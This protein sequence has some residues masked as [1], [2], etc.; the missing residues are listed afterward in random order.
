MNQDLFHKLLIFRS[1]GIGAVKYHELI[2]NC[3]GPEQAVEALQVSGDLMDSVRREIDLAESLGIKFV[4]DDSPEF[5]EA[6]KSARNHA[7]VLSVRGNIKT[8]SK[9]TAGMVGTR[10]AT[11][12]GIEFMHNLAAEFAKRGYAVVS[13]MAMG[14]DSAAHLGALSAGG[15]SM[16]IAVMAGGAD[17]IW[18]KENERLYHEIVERGCVVSDMPVGFVPV[19]NNFIAR[20]RIVAGL[21][22]MLIL[23]E[24]DENS[25][26]VATAGF[27]LEIGRPLWAVPS[28][29]SDERSEG[30]NRFIKEGRAKLC[31]GA[32]DF[33]Q[34]AAEKDDKNKKNF[35]NSALL[36]LIGSVPVSESVLTSLAQKNISETLAE[37]VVLELNGLVRK[38]H[39][40][41]VR[42]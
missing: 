41:Y 6:Y 35:S 26:S 7:P 23:G 14:T 12:H 18:P 9:K 30:P 37:L 25:G 10:H 34:T 42:V 24:A 31:R 4:A 36:D 13:G 39:G 3:G 8:M 32:S 19:A 20:N 11:A 5:P 16:T 33:F 28:H 15:D 2:S 1:R 27:A 22:E 40:G 17:Y 38:T 21:S 29:P